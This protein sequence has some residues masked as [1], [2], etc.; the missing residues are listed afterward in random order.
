MKRSSTIIGLLLV[1]LI[2][3]IKRLHVEPF[4]LLK[5][6]LFSKTSFSQNES[7]FSVV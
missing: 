6:I 3:G 1:I 2:A 4:L 5:R 7:L